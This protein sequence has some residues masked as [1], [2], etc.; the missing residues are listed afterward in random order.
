MFKKLFYLLMIFLLLFS[1]V[2]V[3][4]AEEK[5]L[6]PKQIRADK[7]NNALK[8]YNLAN[9]SLAEQKFNQLYNDPELDEGLEFSVLY[10]LTKT[11]INKYQT[12]KAQKYLADLEDLGYQSST[13]YWDM[14]KLYL[15]KD[16][17]FDSADFKTA[18]KYLEKAEK[19]ELNDLDFKRDL[20]YASLENK[21][22][23]KAEKLYQEIIAANAA[24]SDYLNLAKIKE[25]KKEF[26]KA[27]EYY[28]SALDLN[29]SQSSLYL[30]LGNLYQK[31][32][33]YNSAISIY[34]Q[35]LKKKNNFVP[36][37][38]GLGESNIKLKNYE[39]AEKALK[40]AVK[41]NNNSY[42]GYYL[43]G[44][45]EK[46]RSNYNQALEYYKQSLKHNN[47]YVEAYLAEGRIH[48]EREEYY[49]AISRF[50]LAVEK[51]PEYAASRY[52]LGTA[53]YKAKMLEAA[54]AELRKTL[55]INDNHQKARDLLDEI[56]NKLGIND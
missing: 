39:N 52:Y 43:L 32:A 40:E 12:V 20:A 42:Y 48:L 18:L 46:E 38:I 55:H 14:G 44:N 6:D 56:E 24:A 21:K 5:D 34:N 41:I 53:Y 31:L 54:R 23:N 11:S 50:S 33:N 47:K 49:K 10:Y 8:E 15:N 28:E 16:N 2:G 7:F 51:N 37:Y 3:S 26:N 45:I 36:Y 19:L 30:N 4:L 9:Y 29:A 13:L 22:I 25:N 17:K 1:L 27:I 35:G